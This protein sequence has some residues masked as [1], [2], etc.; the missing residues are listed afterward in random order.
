MLIDANV[1]LGNWPFTLVPPLN[2]A[3]LAAHLRR[4]GI[5]RALVSPIAAI[6]APDP[7]PAN[8][9]LFAAVRRLPAL[10]PAPVVNPALAHWREQLDFAAAGP[11]RALKLFPN[12]HNYRLDSR[13]FD[14]FFKA[15]K[16]RRLRLMISA[17]V[18]DDR[19]RYFGLHIK[20]VPVKTLIPFL[21]RHPELHPLLLGL[22]LPQLRELAKKCDNFST[23]T[24]FIEWMDSLVD[25][26]REFPPR[27]VLLGTH[28]PFLVTAASLAKLSAAPLPARTR[29]AIGRGNAARFFSL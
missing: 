18:E 24:S 3:Q 27:R 8:R 16:S 22:G 9:A 7:M 2:A 12:Y 6:L 4:H 11:A 13:R 25:F 28:A 14:A 1:N 23:D 21:R 19:H 10:V 15:V 20:D 26:T 5:G 17:R 29:A